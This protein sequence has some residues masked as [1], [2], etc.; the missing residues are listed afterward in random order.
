[1]IAMRIRTLW[2]EFSQFLVNQTI[3]ILPKLSNLQK[4][5]ERPFNHKEK[6]PANK[7]K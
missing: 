6:R 1:M 2:K 5:G 3:K 7:E 4:T